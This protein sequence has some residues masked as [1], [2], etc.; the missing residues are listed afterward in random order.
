MPPVGWLMKVESAGRALRPCFCFALRPQS[1]FHNSWDVAMR[2]RIRDI[3][4]TRTGQL[5]RGQCRGPPSYPSAMRGGAEGM[6][7][8]HDSQSSGIMRQQ[9]RGQTTAVQNQRA[10]LENRRG[11]IRK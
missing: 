11:E 1:V 5:R 7:P 10:N 3:P 8:Y 2:F 4:G 6:L 9:E